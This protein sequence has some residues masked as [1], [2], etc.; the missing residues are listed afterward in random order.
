MSPA[1]GPDRGVV[2]AQR[3]RRVS[4]LPTTT[5]SDGSPA[6]VDELVGEI[7]ATD[8]V[9]TNE[10]RQALSQEQTENLRTA[11]EGSQCA[12]GT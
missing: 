6:I 10:F 5:S 2:G 4:R 8:Q 12:E 1:F 3:S 7:H 9:T 11:I